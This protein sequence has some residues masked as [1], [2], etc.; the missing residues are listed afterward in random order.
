M[1]VAGRDRWRRGRRSGFALVAVLVAVVLVSAL[2]AAL[3]FATT[4]ETLAVRRS[5]LDTRA[6]AAAEYGLHGELSAWDPARN[7]DA[8]DGMAVG[9]ARSGGSREAP[10]GGEARVTI[11]R[12]SPSL[13]W[14]VSDGVARQGSRRAAS[15]RRTAIVARLEPVLRAPRAAVTAFGPLELSGGAASAVQREA[16]ASAGAADSAFDVEAPLPLAAELAASGA[17]RV[18]VLAAG[19]SARFA[20]PGSAAW[21]RLAARAAVQLRADGVAVGPAPDVGAPLPVVYSPGPLRLDGVRLRGIVVVDGD[22]VLAGGA[23]IEGIAIVRD[24][25]RR[26]PG[27]GTIRG[28]LVVHDRP[29][30]GGVLPD[31]ER[32]QLG[33]GVRVHYSPCAVARAL[34]ASARLVPISNRA[35]MQ[36][37]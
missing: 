12:L 3:F 16:C 27:G 30:D 10:G 8:P 25:L 2:A 1:S 37:F 21:A 13:F 19:D 20:V 34:R 4:Q 29:P 32:T 26:G 17:L 35:W 6:F 24:D 5:V 14:I 22:L 23:E 33:A 36:H 15:V 7:L 18:R 28:A 11:T 9:E 31:D